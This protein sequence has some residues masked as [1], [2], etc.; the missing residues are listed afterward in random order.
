MNSLKSL[1][2]LVVLV[3]ACDSQKPA[4]QAPQSAAQTSAQTDEAPQSGPMTLTKFKL[5]A[6]QRTYQT[7]GAPKPE[8]LEAQ[9]ILKLNNSPGFVPQGGQEASGSAT[10]EVKVTPERSEVLMFGGIKTKADQARGLQ[11]EILV[12]DADIENKALDKIAEVAVD[13]FVGRVSAQARVAHASDA[14]MATL[15]DEPEAR[16]VALQ[17][18]R[19]RRL[20]DTTPKIRALLQ[21]TDARVQVAAAA[22]LVA[23]EDTESYGAVIGLAETFSRDRNPQLLPLIYIIAD[24]PTDEAKTYLQTLADAHEVE[25]VRKVAKEALDKK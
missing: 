16:L 7:E 2:V 24:M 15:L 17:E 21:D 12:S 1:V 22:A 13:R 25:A 8:A 11:A 3:A 23:F 14:E 20:R 10:Y 6:S 9:I 5:I 19:D 18:I 4:E